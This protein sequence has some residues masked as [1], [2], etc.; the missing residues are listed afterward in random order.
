MN[1]NMLELGEK[2]QV[3]ENPMGTAPILPLIIKMSL[4][5]MFSMIIQ[6]LY[7]IVDSM[8]VS[9]LSENALSAVSM[10]FPVQMLSGAVSV[11]TGVGIASLISRRLGE[12]NFDAAQNAACHGVLLTIPGYLIFL[13]FGIFGS[14]WFC[15]S[16]STID[17]L[18]APATQY[19]TI[20]CI[21]SFFVFNAITIER[22]MQSSGNMLF[23]MYCQLLGAVSNIILDPIMI[24]GLYG[25]PRLEVAGAA[26]AT[27]TSQALS[28][29]AAYIFL[30]FGRFPI[31]INFK[32]FKWHSQTVKDIYQVALPSMIMQAVSSVTSLVLNKIL[33]SFSSTAMAVLGVYS[34]V[35]SFVFMPIFGMN[36]GTMPIMG[37]NYGA[38]NKKRLLATFK[39][40]LAIG[41]SIMILG[42]LIFQFFPERLVGIFNPSEEM[43]AMGVDAFR[44]ISICFPFAALSIIPGTL[45]Q[46]TGHG[47]YSM[48]TS[49]LRQVL[50]IMPLAYILSRSMGV[51]GVWLAYP[52]AE[53]SALI[54]AWILL[55]RLYN[56][57]IKPMPD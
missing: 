25:F 12:K 2:Q 15:K 20:V 31:R 57:E 44:I 21:G 35:Q 36:Q 13:L 40:T 26:Y 52:A 46:A 9:Q 50:F 1:K 48:I 37:Y 11:G 45:F 6:A 42:C 4:P 47:I 5:A 17:E 7:N 29:L 34:K 33:I 53:A 55:A 14:A 30:Y 10:V 19:C 24:F 43:L 8:Y 51:R 28:M 54:V 22:I 16:F 41:F 38:K 39:N 32:G 18:V 56:K 27:I 3:S 23:P 49:I